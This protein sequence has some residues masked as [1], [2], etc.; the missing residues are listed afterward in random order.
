MD[1]RPPVHFDLVPIDEGDF[2]FRWEVYV[3]AIKPY[4][5]R[6]FGWDDARQ[7]DMIRSNLAQG[8]NHTAIEVDGERAGIAQIEETGDRISLHQIELLPT[9]QGRGIGTALVGTLTARADAA[10]KPVHLSVF[11]INSA[12]RRLYE[13][14]GFAVVSESSHD[15]QMMYTPR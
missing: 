6:I 2:A 12:A 9:F 3:A 4:I 11:H 5:D 7:A 15:V 14:L 1:V 10:G 8:G 13:R